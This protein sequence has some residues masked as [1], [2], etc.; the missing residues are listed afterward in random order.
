MITNPNKTIRFQDSDLVTTSIFNQALSSLDRI[1]MTIDNVSVSSGQ[2]TICSFNS[3]LTNN[4]SIFL[5]IKVLQSS[6]VDIKLNYEN[7]LGNQQYE[8]VDNFN[9]SPDTYSFNPVY[10]NVLPQS[11]ISIVVSSNNN[12]AILISASALAV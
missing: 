5:S 9:F 10:I 8:I 11:Q 12:G 7:S 1:I 3:G 4:I 6:N 2:Q